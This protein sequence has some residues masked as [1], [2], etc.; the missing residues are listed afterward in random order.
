MLR[1]KGGEFKAC[2]A[3][4]SFKKGMAVRTCVSVYDECVCAVRN[5]TNTRGERSFVGVSFSEKS[6]VDI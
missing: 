6:V 5:Q 1:Q 2:L 4:T 3:H